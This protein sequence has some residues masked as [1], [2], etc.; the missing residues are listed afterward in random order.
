MDMGT[1]G[2]GMPVLYGNNGGGNDMNNSPWWPLVWLAFLGRNGGGL[3]GGG[4]TGAGGVAFA[5]AIGRVSQDVS[6]G[7]LANAQQTAALQQQACSNTQAV[8]E[9]I[10]RAAADAAACC[11]NTR[12]DAANQGAL[13]REAINTGTF[14]TQ[15]G[16]KDLA[17]QNCQSFSG[18]QAQIAACCCDTQKGILEQSN[19]I[20]RL[21]A[22]I[23]SGIQMQTMQLSA[24][25]S[26]DTQRI[27]DAINSQTVTELQDKLTQ[28]RSELSNCNQTGAIS[29]INGNQTAQILAGIQASMNQILTICG[30]SCNN[31]GG[32]PGPPGQSSHQI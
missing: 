11:C 5:D 4:E 29:Q 31:G 18:L 21:G 25:N 3:F 19:T 30:C 13:T 28:C 8:T 22:D 9:S 27:L 6:A 17:L 12:L 14:V 23:N 10:N 32:P 16:F 2:Q 24:Q 1:M 26:A 20:Q 7:N 15:G